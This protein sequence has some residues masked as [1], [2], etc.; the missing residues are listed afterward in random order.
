MRLEP[1]TINDLKILHRKIF[2]DERGTFTR[3]FGT[4]EMSAAGRP[5]TVAH[6][7]TSTSTKIGTLRGVH[8]QYP[9]FSEAKIVACTSGAVWDVAVDLRPNSLTQFKWFGVELTPENGKSLVIP[10]GF[11]HAFLTLKPNSTLVYAVSEVYSPSNEDGIRYDDALLNIRWP[12]EP[13]TISKKD[14]NW[15]DVSSRVDA[16]NSNFSL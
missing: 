8:F 4:D 11:G 15:G 16:I 7:N 5:T 13:E 6:I 9:P 12:I 3:L 14:L 10:E 1:T 2:A